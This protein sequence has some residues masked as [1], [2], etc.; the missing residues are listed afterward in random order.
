MVCSKD[1]ALQICPIKAGPLTYVTMVCNRDV[2]LL[3]GPVK[4]D[5][6]HKCCFL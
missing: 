6:C 3:K 4:G 5:S 2:A 1:V